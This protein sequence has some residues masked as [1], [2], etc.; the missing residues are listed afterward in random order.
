MEARSDENKPYIIHPDDAKALLAV[1][2]ES[3][4]KII[5]FVDQ[6][7]SESKFRPQKYIHPV[8]LFRV[9]KD[10]IQQ[11]VRRGEELAPIQLA[12][13]EVVHILNQVLH[14][15][16]SIKLVRPEK[17]M[18]TPDVPQVDWMDRTEVQKL[19]SLLDAVR[20][21]HNCPIITDSF[22]N[23]HEERRKMRQ[24]FD[25]IFGGIFSAVLNRSKLRFNNMSRVIH[26]SDR[27]IERLQNTTEYTD[28]QIV[29]RTE[30][31]KSI[32]K[33][34][35]LFPSNITSEQYAQMAEAQMLENKIAMEALDESKRGELEEKITVGSLPNEYDLVWDFERKLEFAQTINAKL[36]AVLQ[37][38]VEK[39]HTH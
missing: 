39:L 25:F 24:S 5:S 10:R 35:D 22:G 9:L 7:T 38:I 6:M 18:S 20:F 19:E 26:E 27:F 33:L 3:K 4:G 23:N 8:D 11:S 32:Q 15:K 36:E 13:D 12:E 30:L 2:S 31:L 29:K 1:K 21:Y 14:D 34:H 37:E 17:L 16:N 28:S